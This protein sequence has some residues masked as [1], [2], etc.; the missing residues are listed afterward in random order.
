M[1]LST[2]L[3]PPQ[4]P[5]SPVETYGNGSTGDNNPQKNMYDGYRGTIP[6]GYGKPPV[7]MSAEGLQESLR[8]NVYDPW[9]PSVRPEGGRTYQ[10][11]WVNPYSGVYANSGDIGKDFAAG[12]YQTT[13][14][15]GSILPK[16][17]HFFMTF[18]Q[19]FDPFMQKKESEYP[20][21]WLNRIPRGA[22][23][24]FDGTVHE[25]RIYRGGLSHYSG[26]SGW[27]ELAPDPT[28]ADACGP[29]KY[30]TYQYAW[31]TLAWSGKKTAWG[32]DPI[33][34]EV[35][36]YTPKAAE[37]LGWILETGVKF[38]TAIQDVWN[39]DMFIYYTVLAKRSYVMT[40]SYRGAASPRY[41]YQPYCKFGDAGADLTA[42]KSYV[43]KPFI[44]IDAT[45]GIEPLN[46]DVLDIVRNQLKRRCPE[47]AVGMIGGE[48]MF[49]IAIS[50]EDVEKYIRGN[51]EERRYWI[52]ANP[53]AL[54]QH[55]GFAPTTFRR[56]TITCDDDQL[57]FKLKRL[58]L[59][60]TEDEA[61]NYGNVGLE[62]FKGKPVWIAEVVDPEIAGRPG[63]N[64]SPVPVPNPE[65]DLA[66]IAIAPIFMNKVFTNLFVPDVTNL[67]SGT[68][69]GPK[70]GLN[71]K[72][73]WY[74]IQTEQNP[75]QKIGNFKGEFQIVPKPDV[76]VFD[77][78]SFV[79]RRCME[80][81]PSLCPVEN[82]RVNTT[83]AASGKT[84]VKGRAST[85]HANGVA[86]LDLSF[87]APLAA[88]VGTLLKV[89]GN[90]YT[91][92]GSDDSFDSDADTLGAEVEL[93][94]MV[95][96]SLTGT[97]K[98]VQVVKAGG[99]DV[100]A[101]ADYVVLDGASV[102]VVA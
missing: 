89:A 96:E 23:Q 84:T 6:S 70:Q 72:W 78:I 42:V 29:M 49:A 98:K 79:Y 50:A 57:R 55:Y 88:S 64:G 47:S 56:W 101:D 20:H 76:C 32:S 33:C 66:E 77:C 91:E 61:I 65:Y 100:A 37:Q 26:L 2:N 80:P 12:T 93:V 30:K 1:A 34:I 7:T 53:Q 14:A 9:G 95:Y 44:V 48:K 40:S 82:M 60:Y 4:L 85:A 54:I 24:L 86:T 99:A 83:A 16:Y 3:T 75:D 10:G 35:L 27:E 97:R 69:F 71:G 52:E 31:E 17:N 22:Y 46:F 68:W 36:K 5:T 11:P 73:A 92:A 45:E 19:N 25:T 63:I 51:E 81:L 41:V 18:A 21:W 102:E 38:G 74:N 39:R 28:T 13:A 58:I 62:E 67:G 43:S 8:L 87:N 15:D 94:C 59:E 90:A